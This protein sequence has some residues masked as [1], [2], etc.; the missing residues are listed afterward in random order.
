[1]YQISSEKS[2]VEWMSVVI[3]DSRDESG[4]CGILKGR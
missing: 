4:A 1:M 3:P 2:D